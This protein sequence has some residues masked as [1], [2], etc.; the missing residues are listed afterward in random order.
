[1][2]IPIIPHDEPGV[3]CWGCLVPREYGA[4][5]IELYCN[6][7]GVVVVRG[8]QKVEEY[9][10]RFLVLCLKNSFTFKQERFILVK[11]CRILLL[12][13]WLLPTKI[14]GNCGR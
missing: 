14:A 7:C 4:G 11:R 3:E 12:P 8:E 10:G 9:V 5:D 6:E 13:P 1:M 2:N